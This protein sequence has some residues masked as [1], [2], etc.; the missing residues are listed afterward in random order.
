MAV[1]IATVKL[2]NHQS[3]H[4]RTPM[5]AQDIVE[6]LEFFAEGQLSFC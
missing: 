5:S 6:L 4:E 3:L 1:E 2:E